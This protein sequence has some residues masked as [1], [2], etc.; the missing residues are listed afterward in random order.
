MIVNGIQALSRSHANGMVTPRSLSFASK[1]IRY[2]LLPQA[3]SCSD[4][5]PI[6]ADEDG[7]EGDEYAGGEDR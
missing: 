4:K 7:D 5:V 3:Q 1:D 2:L 6:D